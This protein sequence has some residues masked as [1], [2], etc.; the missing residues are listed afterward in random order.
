LVRS[1]R[2]LPDAFADIGE[3]LDRLVALRHSAERG[4]GIGV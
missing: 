2:R 1:W 3:A 4:A